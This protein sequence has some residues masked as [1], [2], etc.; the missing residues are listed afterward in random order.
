MGCSI[1]CFEFALAF[2]HIL[3]SYTGETDNKNRL[4][5]FNAHGM[6]QAKLRNMEDLLNDMNGLKA[7]N[8]FIFDRTHNKVEMTLKQLEK[9]LK[10]MQQVKQSSKDPNYKYM[11]SNV[12]L[13]LLD[14]SNVN[15]DAAPLTRS[16]H[17]QAS[18]K[19]ISK[20]EQE[21]SKPRPR[22]SY[23]TKDQGPKNVYMQLT[24]GPG[25]KRKRTMSAAKKAVTTS[26]LNIYLDKGKNNNLR[27]SEIS[28]DQKAKSEH[29]F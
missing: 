16:L 26:H 12:S 15:E 24:T 3:N 5:P 21:I 11:K 7:K 6:K 25:S 19:T 22:A 27:A 29:N 13:S 14:E 4:Q 10:E 8:N 28:F 1:E 20:L 18:N 23:H 9:K 2:D 17:S